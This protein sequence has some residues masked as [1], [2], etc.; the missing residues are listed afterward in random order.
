MLDGRLDAYDKQ[1]LGFDTLASPLTEIEGG[2]SAAC[3]QHDYA[4]VTDNDARAHVYL[5]AKEIGKP[6]P[7]VFG[8][9]QPVASGHYLHLQWQR[10][11]SDLP[12]FAPDHDV[13]SLTRTRVSQDRYGLRV[14]D[15]DSRVR[16]AALHQ[17][18]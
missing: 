9:E 5:L 8:N 13:V 16:D 2:R 17:R 7:A 1:F 15:D 14:I 18:S 12:A 11:G 10:F 3:Q 6:A 4:L